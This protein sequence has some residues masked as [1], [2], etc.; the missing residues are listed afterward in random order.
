MLNAIRIGDSL[1]RGGEV[2][3][4]S[5]KMTIGGRC[6]ARKGDAVKCNVHPDVIQNV[7]LEGDSK[8]CDAGSPIA[9]HGHHAKCGCALISSLG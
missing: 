2:V 8:I 5:N 9:R 1:E 3:E 4:G 7:I 6:V